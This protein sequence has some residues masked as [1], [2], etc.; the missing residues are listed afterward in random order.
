MTFT[1]TRPQL[2]D[3]LAG[4][5]LDTIEYTGDIGALRTLVSVLDTTDPDFPIV[6]P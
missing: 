3:L 1:L 5:G 4:K 6:T 2:L